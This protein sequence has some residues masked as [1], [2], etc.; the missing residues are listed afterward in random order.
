MFTAKNS[1][2]LSPTHAPLGVCLLYVRIREIGRRFCVQLQPYLLIWKP[3][4][5]VTWDAEKGERLDSEGEHR[6]GGLMLS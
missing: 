1:A 5:S 2:G 3:L 6:D 4:L